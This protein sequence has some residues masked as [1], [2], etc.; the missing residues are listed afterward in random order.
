[1]EKHNSESKISDS[2]TNWKSLACCYAVKSF[3]NHRYPELY[4]SCV[5]V[6]SQFQGNLFLPKSGCSS[7]REGCEGWHT[8]PGGW[9]SGPWKV[10]ADT[11]AAEREEL[12]EI[13]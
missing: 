2:E 7:Q 12:E 5:L 4:F 10:C 8:I 13:S 1:M 9:P 6:N 11:F 3:C